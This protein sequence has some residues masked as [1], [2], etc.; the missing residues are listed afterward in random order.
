MA[1]WP[2]QQL[3]TLRRHHREAAARCPPLEATT[4][5]GLKKASEAAETHSMKDAARFERA[6][7]H[8]I[9]LDGFYIVRPVV[10]LAPGYNLA[11]VGHSGSVECVRVP[12]D[13]VPS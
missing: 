13:E 1:L 3:H 4:R 11:I 6:D 2:A 10:N 12:I 9:G 8:S 5:E 7:G